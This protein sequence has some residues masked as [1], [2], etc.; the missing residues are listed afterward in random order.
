MVNNNNSSATTHSLHDELKYELANPPK[1]FDEARA[2]LKASIIEHTLKANTDM[3]GHRTAP[4]R[5][6]H[7]DQC[8]KSIFQWLGQNPLHTKN[9]LK[10]MFGGFYRALFGIEYTWHMDPSDRIS[11]AILSDYLTNLEN[12]DRYWIRFYKVPKRTKLKTFI[13]KDIRHYSVVRGVKWYGNNLYPPKTM[14]PK[15]RRAFWI[16]QGDVIVVRKNGV[17]IDQGIVYDVEYLDILTKTNIVI[18]VAYND[19]KNFVKKI[20]PRQINDKNIPPFREKHGFK[21]L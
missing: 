2:I 13:K 17:D 15:H 7:A 5:E 20:R 10:Y 8:V 19:W 14:Q 1:N 3:T 11:T 16:K 21:R 6:R 9:S 12:E 4:R 18:R